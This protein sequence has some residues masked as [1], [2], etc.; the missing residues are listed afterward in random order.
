MMMKPITALQ[1]P[2]TI[3]GKRDR[4]QDKR[5]E[6]EDSKSAGRQRQ[7]RRAIAIPPW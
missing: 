3:Q 4:E 1:N 7:L 6:I 2:A 5:R